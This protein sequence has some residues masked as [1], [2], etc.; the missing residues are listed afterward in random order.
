MV[1]FGW[2]NAFFTAQGLFSLAQTHALLRQ[3]SLR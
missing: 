3:S 1:Q 2:P